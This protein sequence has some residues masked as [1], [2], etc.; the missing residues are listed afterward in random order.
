MKSYIKLLTLGTV[1]AGATACTDLDVNLDNQ[2]TKYPDNPIAT[3]AKFR[4]CYSSFQSVL[5]RDYKGWVL[6]A[7]WRWAV[8]TAKTR[9]SPRYAPY[10]HSTTLC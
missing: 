2:Y 8:K 5:N 9:L 6:N 3:E 10:A 7:L 1:F 4:G